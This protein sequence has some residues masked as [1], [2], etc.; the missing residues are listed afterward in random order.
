MCLEIWQRV[1]SLMDLLSL[2]NC[3]VTGDVYS[4]SD[5]IQISGNVTTS[6]ISP[7]DNTNGKRDSLFTFPK[8]VR[9]KPRK[10]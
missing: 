10:K 8:L 4:L 1:F 6:W 2:A 5:S 9:N 3:E 7:P